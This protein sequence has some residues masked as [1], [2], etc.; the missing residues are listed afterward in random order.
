MKA[1]ITTVK[2]V[3][4]HP[5]APRLS[6][7][8]LEGDFPEV[9]ANLDDDGNLRWAPGDVVAYIPENA[10]VP[11]DVLKERG[12]WEEGKSKG[13][14]GGSKGNRV[15]MRNFAGV[16]SRGLIFRC[17]PP[18]IALLGDGD[19][20]RGSGEEQITRTVRLG[21]DVGAFLDLEEY[22]PS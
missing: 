20:V 15:K 16:E 2:A 19:L 22:F 11:E 7:V 3:R 17:E 13:M 14:L 5:V 18:V 21:D 10:I 12:Y 9:V 1:P 6:I 4:L 8:T